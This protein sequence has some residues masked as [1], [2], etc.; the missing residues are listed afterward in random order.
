MTSWF[1]ETLPKLAEHTWGAIQLDADMYQSTFDALVNLCPGLSPRGYI[2]I[3]DFGE[4]PAC[5]QAVLDFRQ[6]SCI[7]EQ[8]RELDRTAVYWQRELTANQ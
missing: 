6:I 4:L 2:S 8:I 1:S 7:K 5:R 3:D